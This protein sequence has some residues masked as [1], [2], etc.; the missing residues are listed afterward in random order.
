MGDDFGDLVKILDEWCLASG[1]KFNINKT[2]MIPIGSLEY[3]DDVREFRYVN[4]KD[5]TKIEAHIK[6]AAESEPIRILGAWVGNDVVQV[7]TWSRTL[8]KIDAALEQW[9]L[10]NPTMEG[11]RLIVLMVVG[12]MTQYLTKVQG[13]PKEVEDR[14]EKRIRNFM[15][16]E[17]TNVTVNK[18][19]VYAP[20]DIGG[21]NLLDIVARNEVIAITWLKSYLTFGEDRPLWAYVTDKIMSVN[22]LGAEHNV[23]VAVRMCPYLCTNLEALNG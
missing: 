18:E 17:K 13:M 11:R 22:A 14:L 23:D 6:I 9:S 3:R 2:E 4:G 10:G 12:G 21:R 16:A 7:D 19:T 1:A 8:E 5:G 20:K 15:W